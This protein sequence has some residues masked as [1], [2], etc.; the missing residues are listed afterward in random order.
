MLL[1]CNIN[2][3][4]PN[5]KMSN[6]I[7]LRTLPAHLPSLCIPRVFPNIHEKRIRAIL[8]ALQ[9]G[10]I[11]QIDIVNKT[12]EKGEKYNRVFI[13]FHHWFTSNANAETARERLLSGKEIKIIYDG[14]WFWK[15]SAYR[16]PARRPHIQST[17]TPTPILCLDDVSET[18]DNKRPQLERTKPR[19]QRPE[20]Q[21]PRRP[22]P[23]RPKPRP[24]LERH[25][26]CKEI[27]HTQSSSSQRTAEEP[28][29][30]DSI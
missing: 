6:Q 28:I 11:S 20:P 9:L 24:R 2:G 29:N 14:P 30:T 3:T 26:A 17:P 27:S 19:L 21:R 13:H 8:D 18:E 23:Q 16:E 12:T 22:E 4:T 15:V 25:D 1:V 10:E 7:D 5:P